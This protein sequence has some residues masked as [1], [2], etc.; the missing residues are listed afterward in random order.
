MFAVKLNGTYPR[1]SADP[2]QDC[3]PRCSYMCSFQGY[4]STPVHSHP[5]LLGTHQHLPNIKQARHLQSTLLC[6]G[7]VISCF[8]PPAV[9]TLT[10]DHVSLKL[11]SWGAAAIITTGIVLT[12]LAADTVVVSTHTLINIC[13][14]GSNC[15][16]TQYNEYYCSKMFL[17]CARVAITLFWVSGWAVADKTASSVDAIVSTKA[18]MRACAT[19]IDICV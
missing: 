13:N 4:S 1:M 7:G 8:P 11:V 18:I 16:N 2:D 6:F 12:I 15:L 5:F 19:L 14:R 3:N 10:S 9:C 17:T